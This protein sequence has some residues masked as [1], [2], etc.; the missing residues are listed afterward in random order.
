MRP[1]V[2]KPA[3]KSCLIVMQETWCMV[4]S[5]RVLT[6]R[7]ESPDSVAGLLGVRKD[8]GTGRE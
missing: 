4:V 5:A 7:R 8:G 3:R 2:R 1:P 6:R